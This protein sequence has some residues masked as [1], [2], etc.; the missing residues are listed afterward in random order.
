MNIP[1]YESLNRCRLI[2]IGNCLDHGK[3]LISLDDSPYQLAMGEFNFEGA[4]DPYRHCW[5]ETESL[6]ADLTQPEKF[7]ERGDYYRRFSV[8]N[9]YRYPQSEAAQRMGEVGYLD[10]WDFSPQPDGSDERW[11]EY[12]SESANQ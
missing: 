2:A 8:S 5:L 1:Q 3:V 4:P 6:V 7:F 9:V 11:A 10:F 12:Q